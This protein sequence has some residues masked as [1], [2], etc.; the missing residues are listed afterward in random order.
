VVGAAA[1][2]TLASWAGCTV[3]KRNYKTLSF[4]FDGVPDPEAVQ[5]GRISS[6]GVER[7]S[8]VVHRP[9]AEE[10]C[11]QCHRSLQRPSRNDSRICLKCHAPVQS[12]HPR[13]HGPVVATACLWCHVPHESAFPHL[14]RDK[15]RVVCTQCHTP[16]LLNAER[17]PAHADATRGCLECH[18]GHG[19]SGP[20]M[21]R[22]VGASAPA[23]P[24]EPVHPASEVPA[25]E[26]PPRTPG[27]EP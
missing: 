1:L 10:R 3:T 14:M 6:A 4:F 27:N 26:P 18:S 7:L 19:S 25:Q 16:A 9:F 11:D 8:V 17:V 13:M 23:A 22:D 20:Y 2:I 21:L 12:E 24:S 5:E 15:D